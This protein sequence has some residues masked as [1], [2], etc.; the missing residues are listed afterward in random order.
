MNKRVVQLLFETIVVPIV[1]SSATFGSFTEQV[2][3]QRRAPLKPV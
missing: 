1:T 2:G 3:L